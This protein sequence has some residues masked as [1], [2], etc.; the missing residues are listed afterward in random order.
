MN[1]LPLVDR[2]T[3][4]AYGNCPMSARLCEE[5][6]R[7]V[8]D[9]ANVGSQIHDAIGRTIA[10]YCDA[11]ENGS[12]WSVVEFR[13]ELSREMNSVR[14]D[15]LAEANRIM[16]RSLWSVSEL[17]AKTIHPK[18]ILCHD[19]GILERSGQMARD[20][21]FCR[22]TSEID[23]LV[24][25]PWDDVVREIDWKSGHKEYTPT[26]VSESFQFR[27]H[28][29]L[30]FHKYPQINTVQTHVKNLRSGVL[31]RPVEFHRKHD[32]TYW[33]EVQQ[34]AGDWHRFHKMHP[35]GAEARPS[36]EKCRM[37]DAS[38]R[39]Y[40]ADAD[41]A[42]VASNPRNAL[43]RRMAV[44]AKLKEVDKLLWAEVDKSG[45]NIVLDDGTAFGYKP[46]KQRKSSNPVHVVQD[47][48][49]DTEDAPSE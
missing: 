48:E 45:D 43:R 17:L 30:I 22:V 28:A 8:G 36:R 29:T 16:A 11:M 27:L 6:V 2:S 12:M 15:Y 31:T 3:L 21:S 19:G 20:L 9:A 47:S 26:M 37:C 40:E 4:E 18:N 25:T 24:S 44:A 1:D 13:D 49:E 46:S 41:I 33:S 38:A 5:S 35:K 10:A 7:S 23:L 32:R 42:D 39:C 14:A 34:R